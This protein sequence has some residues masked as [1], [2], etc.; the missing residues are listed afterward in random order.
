MEIKLYFNGFW[1]GFHDGTNATNDKFFIELFK[2]V[3][4]TENIIIT[5]YENANI[6]VENTQVNDSKKF[7]KSWLH[8]YLFS[9]E[10]Y[11][12]SD[13]HEYT[14]VLYGRRNYK[15]VVNCPEYIP[16]IYSSYSESIINE[17]KS[18]ERSSIPPNDCVVFITNPNG[19]TRN[20]FL[21]EL[22][23][24]M[25]ITYAGNYKNNIGGPIT[26]YYN[27]E[28]FHNYISQFKFI[29]TMENS[30]EDTYIT[31]KITHGLFAK[32][33]PVYWGSKRVHDYI[34][35][36]R[37]IYLEN[38][39]KINEV[40]TIMKNMSN[41]E[42]LSCV[43]LPFF[44]D[45]GKQFT[46]QKMAKDIRNIIF[47]QKYPLITQI[48]CITNNTF[49]PLRYERLKNILTG[50]DIKNEN[51]TFKCDTYKHTITDEI[52]NKYIK[53]DIVRNLRPH[54]PSRKSE[55]SLTLNFRYIFEDI[56]KNYKDG[57]FLLFESD[58]I[59][60]NK[61]DELNECFEKLKDKDWD[62]ISLG[63]STYSDTHN[64]CAIEGETPYRK[65]PNI[66]LLKNNNKEDLSTPNDKIRF[67][68]KFHTRCTDSLLFSYNG[69]C[70][71]LKHLQTDENYGAPFD[72]YF[73]DFTENHM[74][75]KFY[76]TNISYFNQLTNMG[77]ENSSI[78]KDSN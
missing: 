32:T 28:K 57:V 19:P 75:F 40:V 45:F 16:Y 41:E 64:Y 77:L 63:Y 53:N 48:Y 26:D 43:N 62:C 74:D 46:V 73:T 50:L 61:I 14:C 65:R 31:E 21:S 17:N 33:I 39:N 6:L 12:R 29:I 69:V 2:Q 10:S 70:K 1:S 71:F 44:T 34:N 15:N 42:W 59:P 9:G 23:K 47:P 18:V 72:Y 38:E 66:L 25:K 52:Y 35:P 56:I 58:V 68:R 7:S 55:L 27:S 37:F 5:N 36:Q 22:E 24:H 30:Q 51:I 8:T 78:Q 20:A 54:V 11:I 13:L 60:Y 49:E 3:Y 67:I 4:Q 76:W